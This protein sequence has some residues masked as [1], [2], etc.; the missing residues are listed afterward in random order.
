MNSYQTSF[1]EANMSEEVKGMLDQIRR[2]IQEATP[3]ADGDG[4]ESPS[5]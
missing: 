4:I 2:E 5:L 3:S 1:V